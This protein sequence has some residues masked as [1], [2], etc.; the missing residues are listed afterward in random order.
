MLVTVY[1]LEESEQERNKANDD[2]VDKPLRKFLNYYIFAPFFLRHS[3]SSET[4]K[5]I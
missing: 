3:A 2:T 1:R 5:C 4:S